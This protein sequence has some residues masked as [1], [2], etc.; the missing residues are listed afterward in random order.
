MVNA[1]SVT[2]DNPIIG[3]DNACTNYGVTLIKNDD[4]WDAELS[5]LERYNPFYEYYVCENH[6]IQI[7]YTLRQQR[8]VSS[9]PIW[10]ILL[11]QDS[12]YVY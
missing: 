2:I 6:P 7:Y 5:E 4:F 9:K 10:E 12:L 8:Y 1:T 3:K 11:I